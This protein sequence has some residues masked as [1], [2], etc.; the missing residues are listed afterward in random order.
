MNTDKLFDLIR[1]KKQELA[2]SYEVS[3]SSIVFIGDN[4]FIVVKNGN[5]IRI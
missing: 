4:H 5:E 3:E 1:R 2:I